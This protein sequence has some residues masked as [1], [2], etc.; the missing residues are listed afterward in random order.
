VAAYGLRN[1]W[2]FSFD[3]EGNLWVGDVGQNDIEEINKVTK[4]G[5]YGWN[6]KEGT[7][8][9]QPH[10]F[11]DPPPGSD[12]EA[13]RENPGR[14]PAG[15]QSIDPVAQYDTHWEGHSAVG[16]HVY[17]GSAIPELRGKYV[18]GE[19]GRVFVTTPVIQG[20]G[21]R[22]AYLE[23]DRIVE[24]PLTSRGFSPWVV[25]GFGQDAGGELYVL[26]TQRGTPGGQT[27]AVMRLLP[28]AGPPPAGAQITT[29]PPAAGPPLVAG[30]GEQPARPAA[31]APAAQPA[32][33][34]QTL[35]RSGDVGNAAFLLAS[36]GGLMT[37]AGLGLRRRA[38]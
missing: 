19:F 18:F 28:A 12:A 26:T 11:A 31:A 36:L 29:P 17:Y 27:G 30:G 34:P 13:V 1:P 3:R 32:Q 21:G 6:Y 15:F 38:R 7:F 23:G 25:M 24:F 2:R 8:W 33:A 35:P 16:G 10:G 9:F 22:L 37:L 20:A 14:A 5:N 4:G